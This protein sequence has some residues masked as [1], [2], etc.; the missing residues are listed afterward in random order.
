MHTWESLL[1]SFKKKHG[2]IKGVK[3]VEYY[4]ICLLNSK[5]ICLIWRKAVKQS[6]LCPPSSASQAQLGS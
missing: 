2:E 3:G 1:K 6:Q 5:L 4:R